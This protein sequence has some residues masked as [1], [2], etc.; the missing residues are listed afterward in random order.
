VQPLPSSYVYLVRYLFLFKNTSACIFDEFMDTFNDYY[1]VLG[2]DADAS[3]DKIKAAFKKLALQYH[4]DVYKGADAQERMRLL[5]IAYQTLSDPQ[6]RKAYDAHRSEHV[7]SV[8]SPRGYVYSEPSR[9]NKHRNEAE[10]SPAARRDR[11]RHYSFPDLR[12]ELPARV[13]LEDIAYDLSPVEAC[14]LREQGMLRGVA[15]EAQQ[16][17]EASPATDNNNSHFCHR[18]HHRWI[19]N[20]P[21]MGSVFLHGRALTDFCPVCG[22]RDWGEYLLLRCLHCSAVFESEQIRYEVGSYN[23][24]DGT[25]CPPYELFPLCPYCGSSGWCPAE[26]ARVS[27]LRALAARRAARLRVVL[28]SIAVVVILVLGVVAINILR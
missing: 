27:T 22:A 7:L 15:I 23:Y 11:Q 21:G 5:L 25:L 10:V 17:G 18:C 3:A 24:G 14:T 12:D 26:D 1:V 4:P 9:S 13:D 20:H 2:V 8:S 19:T 6:E 28:I 16:S